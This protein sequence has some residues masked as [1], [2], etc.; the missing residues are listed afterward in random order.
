MTPFIPLSPEENFC[1][2]HLGRA[3]FPDVGFPAIHCPFL[4]ERV[5]T[6]GV[7]G[8]LTHRRQ[9]KYALDFEVLDE[10]AQGIR[11]RRLFENYYTFNT[12]VLCP[13]D[14]IIVKTIDHVE[15]R[16]IGCQ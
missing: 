9:W 14:G 1:K 13:D 2:F 11:A 16:P 10:P 6:Q 8:R 3:R 15:D 5:V 4:G 12:P 7:D